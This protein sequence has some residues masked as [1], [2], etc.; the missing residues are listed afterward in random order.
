[1][2]GR[3]PWAQK[4]RHSCWSRLRM[5][6]GKRWRELEVWIHRIDLVLKV[7]LT[8]SH[9]ADSVF[10]HRRA[11]NLRSS[12]RNS[13]LRMSSRR[14]SQRTRSNP[15][16]RSC[17]SSSTTSARTTRRMS[18]WRPLTMMPCRRRLIRLVVLESFS[19]GRKD[20]YQHALSK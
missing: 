8:C 20:P 16:E 18:P 13:A 6:L 1:M 2:P 14:A 3:R 17:R 7:S 19:W 15:S 9:L 11:S 4:I 10:W 5:H 12:T